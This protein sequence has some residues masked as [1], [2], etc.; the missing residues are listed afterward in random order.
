[1]KI[2][3]TVMVKPQFTIDCKFGVPLPCKTVPLVACNT[4]VTSIEEV[5]SEHHHEANSSI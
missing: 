4:T 3:W 2:Y 1:M 5:W